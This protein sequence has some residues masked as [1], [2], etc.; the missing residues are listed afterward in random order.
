MIPA[1]VA[2]LGESMAGEDYVLSDGL[3]VSLFLALRQSRPLFLEGEAGVGKTEVAKTLATL[4][5]RRLIRLQ[6][7][8]GLDINAAAYEWNYAR[9]MMQ[10]QSA[11]QGQLSSVDMVSSWHDKCLAG[12]MSRLHDIQN[13]AEQP[14]GVFI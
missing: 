2:E 3:A 6:C 13:E 10:T 8:E 1:T 14:Q 4:L 7:Y 11:G 12:W 5:D 9:Q